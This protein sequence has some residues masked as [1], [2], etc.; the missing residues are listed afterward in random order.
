MFKKHSS[1]GYKCSFVAYVLSTLVLLILMQ[2]SHAAVN[3]TAICFDNPNGYNN[4]TIHLWNS[5]PANV[6]TSTNWPGLSMTQE[7]NF[8]CYDAGASV[9][10]INVIFNDNGAAQTADLTLLAGNNCYQNGN[11]TSLTNCG[12]IPT[13]TA[14]IANAGNDITISVGELA[15]FDA[16]G[17]TDID[18]SLVSYSWSNGLT[19]IM[20]SQAYDTAG[21]YMVTLTVTDNEGATNTDT[22]VVIV[23]DI[24]T[25]IT[26]T[27]TNICYDNA[28]NHATPTIYLWNAFPENSVADLNWPGQIMTKTGDYYCFDT[29]N[30]VTSINTIF[31]STGAGQTADLLMTSPDACYKDG[32]WVSLQA[33]GFTVTG[34]LNVAP[35][36]N[37]GNDITIT[38]GEVANFDASG[39]T[40]P[41]GSIVNYTWSNGLTGIMP[42]QPYNTPGIYNVTLTVTDNE[43]ATS[44]DVIVVT[45][46]EPTTAI[47]LTASHICYDNQQ[48]HATPTIYLWDSIPEN[49]VANLVWPGEAMTETGDYYCYD[50]NN[51]AASIKTIFNSNGAGQSADLLMTSPNACFKEGAWVSLQACGFNVTGIQNIAPTANAGNDVTIFEGENITFDGSGSSDFDGNIVSYTWSNGL[52]GSTPSLAYDTAGTYEV[53][54]TVTDN[55]GATSTDV[56]IVTVEP[57][58]TYTPP[59][60]KAIFYINTNNLNPPYAYLWTVP[61]NDA[62]PDT[63]WPGVALTDFGGLNAWYV[64]IPDEIDTANVIFSENGINQSPD[65]TFTGDNLCYNNG[66][67]MTI[68]ECGIVIIIPP[69][70][71]GDRQVNVNSAIALT[72]K[73]DTN[74]IHQA[75]WQSDAW[76]GTLTGKSVV[77]P[78]L[79]TPG[80]YTVT[81]TLPNGGSDS[82][83]LTVVSST[84]GIAERPLLAESLGFP[85]SGNV[86]N[87]NYTFEP[88]FPNLNG[89]FSSPVM[90][91]NDGVNDLI[92]VVDKKGTL[93][94][95]PNDATVSQ[96]QVVNLLDISAQVRDYHEQ[97][98]LSVVF[99]PN[100]SNNGYAYI[101]YIEGDNDNESDNG[102]FGDGVLERIT[103][104]DTTTPTLATDRIEILRI[105]QSG[106]DHKGGMMQFHPLTGEFFMS[107][108]DGAYGDTAIVP[109]DPD[110]RTNNNSQDNTNLSGSFIRLIMR[111][112][113]NTEGLYYDIPSDNPFVNDDNARDEI[114]SFGH[115]NPWRWA[116][117]TVAPYTLWETEIGQS[118]FEEINIIN[119]GNNYGWPICEG[120]NHRGNDGGDPNYYNTCDG[121]LTAP[122]GGYAHSTGSV[123]IIGGFVYQGTKLPALTGRFIYGDYVS[124]KI[125]SAAIDDTDV[126]ASDAFPS[127][128]SSFG[129]DLSGEEVFI[130][131]HGEEYN[132]L[133]IIYRMLD[134]DVQAAVIPEMLSKTGIFAN[135]ASQFPAQGVIEYDINSDGWFDGLK[136]RHFLSVPND[137]TI[138]FAETQTWDL[139]IGSVLVKHLDLPVSDSESTPFET[140]V[141]FKQNSGKWAAANYRWNTGGTDANLVTETVNETVLQYFNGNMENIEHTVRGGA[142]C[143]SCHI[144]T[145]SKEPLAIDTRQLNKPFDYQGVSD[146]QLDVF[147]N[148]GLF[149]QTINTAQTYAA[150]PDP[151]DT[152]ADINQR[153]RAYLATNCAHCHE[154]AFMDMNYDTPVIDMDI[155]NVK[156]SSVYR[157]LPFDHTKSLIHSYQ[158]NDANRMPKGTLV[159]NLLADELIAQWIDANGASQTDT[160]VEVI[161]TDIVPGSQVTLLAKEIYDNGFEAIAGNTVSWITSNSDIMPVN[162]TNGTLITTAGEQGL[163]T[164]IA[165]SGQFTGRLDVTVLGAPNL[166]T[167][168][169]ATATS[170]S[171]IKLTWTDNADDELSYEVSR[172]NSINGPFSNIATLSA[173]S[174]M[175]EDTGLLASTRYYY[176]LVAT[177]NNANASEVTTDTTTQDSAPI[178]SLVVIGPDTVNLIEDEASQVIAIATSGG[179][180][181]GVTLAA[182]W[183]TS[184]EAIAAVSSTGI[185]TG[186][187]TA[188]IATITAEYQ[189]ELATITVENGG[190]AQYL[191]F[192]KPS[193]WATPTAHIWTNQDG[194]ETIRSG[195]WPGI[196]LDQLSPEYGGSWMRITIPVEWANN[197]G[198]TNILFSNAGLNKTIDLTFNR[199][200][201]AW[202]DDQWLTEPPTGDGI[203]NGTQI[204][205]GNGSVT[206]AGSD[207]LSGKLFAPGTIVD[208]SADAESPGLEF[209]HWEGSGVAYLVNPSAAD[210]QLVVGDA[211]S[212]TLLAVFD[213]VTDTYL[214]GREYYNDKGCAGCHG[215][216]GN[217]STSLLG[218]A[219]T[220]SLAELTSYIETSM[221]LGNA[222]SCSGECASSTAELILNNAYEPPGNTC[223]ATNLDDLVPQDRNFR[224]LSSLEY[225][226]SIR[227]LLGLTTD[228][229]VTTGLIPADIPVNG[230]KTNANTIFTN[231]YAKGYIIAAETAAGMV[232]N[233]YALAPECS[234]MSCLINNFGKRAFRRPL[235]SDESSDLNAIYSQE[236]TL[237]LLTAILS[238]PNMLYRSEIGVPD[239][240]GYYQLTDYEVASMLSYNYWATTPDADLMAS[241]DAGELS[242]AAQISAKVTEMLQDPK[243]EKALER[244]IVGWLDLDKDIKTA[245]LS[246]SLKAD[247]KRESIEFVSR[248]VFEGG[249]YNDL[250]TADYSYMT[251]QLANHYGLSWPG[252]DDW[253]QVNYSAEGNNDQRRGV[254]GHAGILAIQSASEKT[255][256]V[257]RGLFVRKNLMCQEFPPPPVGA[258]L[259]PQEDPSLT[260]RERFETAHLQDGCESCHQ[261]ID[262]IGFGLENYNAQGLFVTTETT[263]D[264]AVKPIDSAGYIG[265]LNSAETF[266]SA[267]GPVV[268]YQGMDQ[269]VQ[270]IAESAHGRSCYARQW[271]RY[272]KGQRESREDSCTMEVFGKV[273]KENANSTMLDLMIR[274]T[275]TK[276][277]TL[278]K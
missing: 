23:N 112:T 49:T 100:F 43:G 74:D 12:L 18:G 212:Y 167:N 248:T 271:Y 247:M 249:N 82:F 66:N 201:P 246:D 187:N 217:G 70:A 177:G 122:V 131:A 161:E 117:D 128:L 2:P 144:G 11:W 106:P 206:L 6:I 183:S 21:T 156:R 231:D 48:N 142:E 16:S 252:G 61:Q 116:F 226:N 53:S 213:K 87:G 147:N 143:T 68:E 124:K 165:S 230:F 5:S 64:D 104:N 96:A 203:E 13:N 188:G 241:A 185:I 215:S 200:N 15:N 126:L 46:N 219:N 193:D 119:K 101:Y 141:L 79:T 262:G 14:P 58:I 154:G 178:D 149:S 274:F 159:T 20:P 240:N 199:A 127:N 151:E 123:S 27:A 26:L 237:G 121:T 158:T 267:E 225:N 56:L 174:T 45:V 265:S 83:V 118:G 184:N 4:P 196:A 250:L 30:T 236:G 113:V 105:P 260:V 238:S 50:T 51:I 38:A 62:M 191:Y 80:T 261:Y 73:G 111:D 173:N 109:T 90:V 179:D 277:Y 166:P 218:V 28:Q 130:S 41:D 140:S 224:L 57:A 227:D 59:A 160:L 204:Q 276:N 35:T 255:H 17:S 244:F 110:R 85:I 39:S 1:G 190:Q 269:L 145:G 65:L 36:S 78:I 7:G 171:S 175:L 125:W 3:E 76:L 146:N 37:A 232:N 138:N 170:G 19:G 216:E 176:Q 75:Q 214:I 163:A 205:V 52:T 234:N 229:D 92:Y 29:N 239:G 195:V 114:W 157:M 182:T 233:I 251:Q 209:T 180:D 257:K 169:V 33:C 89:M 24:Q 67:W 77:T 135:M 8:Y 47:T 162:G 40:D 108:G 139:P 202:Y 259:K 115:R 132:G 207:N 107:I 103:L 181:I 10:S 72:A 93:S 88:A 235:T 71:G 208:I 242:T 268:R 44:T 153:A 97:G 155:M 210:T 94:V 133:S 136:A 254:L 186:G 152:T 168:F 63:N 25:P 60:G 270:L 42:S 222:A 148:I 275:Q 197:E 189:G 198:D 55:D 9:N 129:T 221:P 95:F 120:L 150:Y 220:Y 84:Q 31:N 272:S 243:A 98:L 102:A 211:L 228:V 134:S 264:G 245:A 256:P 273:F 69:D 91:T 192:N 32:A 86:S 34:T 194:V 223:D 253:Q 81:L 172:S 278:R 54:L 137:A 266:L 22:L 99:H 263:D 258:V 164:I